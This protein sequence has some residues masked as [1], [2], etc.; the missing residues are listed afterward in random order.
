[1]FD[2]EQQGEDQDDVDDGDEVHN[3]QAA[4]QL[5]HGQYLL[6]KSSWTIQENSFTINMLSGCKIE[7]WNWIY[8]KLERN[9]VPVRR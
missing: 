5:N 9:Y 6:L 2:I 8:F 4:V 1:M 7:T 3:Y